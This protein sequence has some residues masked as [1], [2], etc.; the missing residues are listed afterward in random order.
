MHNYL[1]AFAVFSVMNQISMRMS[2]EDI[3]LLQ[4]ISHERNTPIASLY[5]QA[6]YETFNEWKLNQLFRLYSKGHIGLK[7]T[8]KLSRMAWA[9]FLLEIERRQIE[10]PISELVDEYTDKIRQQIQL[11]DH[12]K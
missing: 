5:R 1:N 10:P 3:E 12:K 11:D 2:E 4:V 6:T 7:K 8:W 9:E